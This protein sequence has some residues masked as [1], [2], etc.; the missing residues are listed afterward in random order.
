MQKWA[1]GAL[2]VASLGLATLVSFGDISA[3]ATEGLFPNGNGAR[4]RALAGAGSAD[5]K[6]ASVQSLNPASLTYL[7]S[8]EQDNS[9]TLSATLFSPNRG[10]TIS[11]VGPTAVVNAGIHES[12]Q[13]LFVIPN[14]AWARRVDTPLVDVIGLALSATGGMNTDYRGDDNPFAGPGGIALGVNGDLGLNYEAVQL[15]LSL[16]KKFG[17]I[18]LGIQP[19]IVR[20]TL[21]VDG[22]DFLTTSFGVSGAQPGKDTAWGGGIRLGVHLDMGRLR[23]AAAYTS[24]IYNSPFEKYAF[25]LADGGDLDLPQTVQVGL[26]V[27]LAHW[28]LMA[29]YRWIDYSSVAA[30]GGNPNFG[31]IIPAFST[32]GV[33]NG[34]GFGWD[35]THTIKIAAEG[36]NVWPGVD[37]RFGYAYNTQP[38]NTGSRANPEIDAHFFANILAPATVQHHITA[39]AAIRGLCGLG[40]D[41]EFAA[42]YAPKVRVNGAPIDPAFSGGTANATADVSMSQYAI[43]AGVKWG[44]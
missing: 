32:T 2:K 34:I 12:S 18:S 39:G 23:A 5:G 17:A 20:Q 10:Y 43:T 42:S 7:L 4:H 44:W 40:C 8:A 14:M 29:D 27:D 3:K 19:L 31:G 22:L 33:S 21:E 15:Q 25:L 26:A 11:N 9:L 41:L 28:T 38:L 35:D 37:L 24:R 6:D 16:A 30:F 1:A 36:E 13:N